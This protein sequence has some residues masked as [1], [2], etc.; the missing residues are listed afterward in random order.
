MKNNC[1]Q[2]IVKVFFYFCNI[3]ILEYSSYGKYSKII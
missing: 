2:L 1:F 3:I